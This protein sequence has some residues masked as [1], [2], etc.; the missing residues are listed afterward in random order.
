MDDKCQGIDTQDRITCLRILR[1][2]MNFRSNYLI[3][4]LSDSELD[5]IIRQELQEK[6]KDNLPSLD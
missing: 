4:M 2:R 5:I 6:S 3:D 1:G